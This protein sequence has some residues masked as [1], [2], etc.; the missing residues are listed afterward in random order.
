MSIKVAKVGNSDIK[1]F[2]KYLYNF[3]SYILIPLIVQLTHARGILR[4]NFL[5]NFR[6]SKCNL[7]CLKYFYSK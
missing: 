4:P 5:F 7:N 3:N 2:C 6:H 1:F